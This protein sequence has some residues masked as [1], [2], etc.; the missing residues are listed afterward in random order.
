MDK[1]VVGKKNSRAGLGAVVGQRA[2]QQLNNLMT[3]ITEKQ[4]RRLLRSNRFQMS[5]QLV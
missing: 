2:P 5:I 1:N 3:L 4:P